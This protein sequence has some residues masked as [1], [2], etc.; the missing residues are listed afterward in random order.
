MAEPERLFR[1]EAASTESRLFRLANKLSAQA[2]TS[3]SNNTSR[4]TRTE[5]AP[6]SGCKISVPKLPADTGIPLAGNV[7]K[8]A[9][10]K[11]E[12]TMTP[13]LYLMPID[14]CEDTKSTAYNRHFRSIKHNCHEPCHGTSR[15]IK[16][17]TTYYNQRLANTSSGI[18]HTSKLPIKQLSR[19]S[20]MRL[21][22]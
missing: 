7:S 15:A 8:Q 14:K 5:S 13:A 20:F 4:H 22:E 11:R 17:D 9:A 18:K 21:P 10:S 3:T 19:T 6:G 12:T 1:E 16:Q 2:L